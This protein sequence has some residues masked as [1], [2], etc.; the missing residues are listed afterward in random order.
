MVDNLTKT[1]KEKVTIT[2]AAAQAIG[3][4]ISDAFS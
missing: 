3:D 1:P 2:K 4:H